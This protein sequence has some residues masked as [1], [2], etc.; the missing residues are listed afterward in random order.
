MPLPE[1]ELARHD[2]PQ[3]PD[4][5]FDEWLRTFVESEGWPPRCGADG[6]PV[7]RWKAILMERPIVFWARTRW[8]SER[9]SLAPESFSPASQDRIAKM[10]KAFVYGEDNAYGRQL[11]D[12]PKRMLQAAHHI[13]ETGLLPGSPVLLRT[14]E[15]LE[16]LDG[17]HRVTA[18]FAYPQLLEKSE[19][20]RRA[21]EGRPRALKQECWV[22]EADAE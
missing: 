20:F 13:G 1:I 15:G 8:R 9:L 21:T 2:L 4:G 16:I 11:V 7:D 22:G 12:G 10:V 6:V 17:N 3:M 19:V 5:V 18:H 14:N